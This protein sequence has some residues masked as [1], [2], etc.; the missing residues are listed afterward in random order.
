MAG[1][2]N[3]FEDGDVEVDFGGATMKVHRAILA[4]ASPVW[5][6]MFVGEFAE[7]GD[8]AIKFRGD[9]PNVA[10]LCIQLI[11][12]T[13]AES[14]FDWTHVQSC[15][16]SDRDALDAFIDK[17][18]LRGVKRVI[19]HELEMAEEVAVTKAKLVSILVKT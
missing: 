10:S 9:D 18:D 11:Y 13:A 4:Q 6:T 14:S 2:W 16:M 5:K 17:Y 3:G 1:E 8:A 12:S 7:S 19:V 15:A